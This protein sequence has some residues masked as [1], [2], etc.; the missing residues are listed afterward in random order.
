VADNTVLNAGAGGDTV[1]TDDI[2]GVKH[3]LVKV[4]FGVADSATPVSTTNPLPVD[5]TNTTVADGGV[6]P[7][8]GVQIGG[9]DGSVFQVMSTDN[10]GRP[11][12]NV[13]GTVTVDTELPAAAAL[14]DAVA[15]PTVPGVGGF[16]LMWNGATWDR[17]PGSATNGLTANLKALNGT[18]IDTNSG[19]KSAGTQRVILASDQTVVPI[20]DNSGSLTVDATAATFGINNSQ[21][22]G[23]AISVNSGTKDAG[24]QR[25]ILASDQTVVPISDNAGSLTVDAPVGTPA[26]VR[27]SDGA[28]AITA[29]PV[30]D[31][32]GSLT[33][34][35]PVGT[36]VF[37]TVT[38]STTGGWSQSVFAALTNTKTL[39]K[40]SA[41]TF[42][43]YYTIYNPNSS[44]AYV[45]IFDVA[46]TASVTL[47][48]TVRDGLITIPATSA[49]NLEMT[50]GVHMTNGIVIAC[51]TTATGSTAPGTGLDGTILYK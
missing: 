43:G 26:F 37:T 38:P 21:V 22:S 1:A 20:S 15:N 11:N 6:L 8:K 24:T 9:T 46:A 32:A 36:P 33:V 34:D 25:V 47:G 13:N 17:V 10:A 51:T 48:T 16:A 29:L 7:A 44:V 49:A 18:A 3:Q 31:N 39:I 28:A 4:E 30:T 35:A 42:G 2:A 23:T 19:A 27:L 5:Q 45:Q 12:V 50:N 41:G 40:A 14:A